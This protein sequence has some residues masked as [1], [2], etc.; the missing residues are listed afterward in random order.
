MDESGG[1]AFTESRND[2]RIHETSKSAWYLFL[3]TISIGGQVIP[4]FILLKVRHNALL[5]RDFDTA[6]KSSGPWNSQM[7]L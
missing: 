5:T 2:V 6:S 4:P 3:L 1:G 7:D